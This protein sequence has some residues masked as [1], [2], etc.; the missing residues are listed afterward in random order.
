MTDMTHL[1]AIDLRLSMLRS[2]PKSAWIEHR[3]MMAERERES[4]LEFLNK[5]YG[6]VEPQS[7]E[8][9]DDELLDALLN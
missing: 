7:A 3:I 6:Y 5:K 9:S 4:E 2:E 1:N 8:L